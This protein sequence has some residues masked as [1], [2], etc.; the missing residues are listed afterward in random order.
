M[1]HGGVNPPEE[2]FTPKLVPA[3]PLYT[4]LDFVLHAR[5]RHHHHQGHLDALD[6]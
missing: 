6:P 2:R 4:F 3:R 5:A 1:Q